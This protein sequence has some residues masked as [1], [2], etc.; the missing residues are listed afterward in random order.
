MPSRKDN[1]KL[2]R[3]LKRR[4]EELKKKKKKEKTKIR[5]NEIRDNKQLILTKSFHD[6][7]N[8]VIENALKKHSETIIE[9][10][11][12]KM[13]ESISN[14]EDNI[15]NLIKRNTFI[16]K[17]TEYD[18]DENDNGEKVLSKSEMSEMKLNGGLSMILNRDRLIATTEKR[19]SI[20][21]CVFNYVEVKEPKS[22]KIKDHEVF[23]ESYKVRVSYLLERDT[24]SNK[25]PIKYKRSYWTK[26][27]KELV[28]DLDL[29]KYWSYF[30][31]HKYITKDD[32]YYVD[33]SDCD[34]DEEI[35]M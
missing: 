6:F 8:D 25:S 16:Q 12:Q 5:K 33:H 14:T 7:L 20:S 17:C 28:T 19:G 26:K 3:H 1:Y 22:L 32:T 15:S 34:T 4:K 27:Q 13:T 30:F 9:R 21:Y 35:E 29:D 11:V 31:D 2:I 18:H 10:V 23:Y 24:W